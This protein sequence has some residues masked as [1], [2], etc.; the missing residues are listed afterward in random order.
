MNLIASPQLHAK[1]LYPACFT[2]FVR[3]FLQNAEEANGNLRP[4]EAGET[5]A[6][7]VNL[8]VLPLPEL[9]A[10]DFHNHSYT[11]IP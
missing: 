10:E 6:P 11:E 8:H 2:P 7:E 3:R 5:V 9:F 1:L 4:H